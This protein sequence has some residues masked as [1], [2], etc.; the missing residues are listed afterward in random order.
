MI[1]F[2][3]LI[4]TWAIARLEKRN[5][6]KTTALLLAVLTLCVLSTPAFATES[7]E[8]STR[9]KVRTKMEEKKAEVKEKAVE[10]VKEN[11]EKRTENRGALLSKECERVS[12][13]V[14]ELIS[15]IR[16]RIDR[17]KIEGRNMSTAETS[18]NNAKTYLADAESLCDQ[19][20]AKFDTVPTDDKDASKAAISEARSLA[21]QSREK[22]VLMRKA[23]AETVKAIRG[24]GVRTAEPTKAPK[25]TATPV[26]TEEGAL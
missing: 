23:L 3:E 5:H 2:M 4:V 9:E 7:M 10:R 25:P 21:K 22:F 18:L 6:M 11:V 24:L 15:K 26:T 14:S 12:T 20:V 19:A 8:D 1:C 16:E 17:A 13:N